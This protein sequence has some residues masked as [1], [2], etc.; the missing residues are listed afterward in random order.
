MIN[1]VIV[2]ECHFKAIQDDITT[3]DY[4][5]LYAS[6]CTKLLLGHTRRWEGAGW[7]DFVKHI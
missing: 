5:D 2:P 1:T 7:G 6:H 3:K 4:S